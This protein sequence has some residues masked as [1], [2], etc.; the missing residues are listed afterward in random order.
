MIYEYGWWYLSQMT[1]WS[2]RVPSQTVKTEGKL[3]IIIAYFAQ[4]WILRFKFTHVFY[5]VKAA[6]KSKANEIFEKLFILLPWGWDKNY[7]SISYYESEEFRSSNRI[8]SFEFVY[9]FEHHKVIIHCWLFTFAYTKLSYDALIF[10][11]YSY[12]WKYEINSAFLVCADEY[13]H[14]VYLGRAN[15]L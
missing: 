5:V 13:L 3:G 15:W 4:C 14:S 8:Q 11:K 7:T 6:D 2:A 1:V 10:F 9:C 12:L